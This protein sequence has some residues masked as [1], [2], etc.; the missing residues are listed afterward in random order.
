MFGAAATGVLAT[1]WATVRQVGGPYREPP[2]NL[3]AMSPKEYQVFGIVGDFLIPPGGEL[4]GSAGDEITL[5][6]VDAFIHSAM[7][8]KRWLMLSLAHVFEHGTALD[9]YGARS[10]TRLPPHLQRVDLEAWATSTTLVS[11]QLWMA[12]KSIYA[13]PY[14]DRPDVRDAMRFRAVCG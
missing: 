3:L 1:A 12:A 4:P 9:R 6:G 10:L 8:D 5:R 7:P 2:P 11:A 13:F 14:F